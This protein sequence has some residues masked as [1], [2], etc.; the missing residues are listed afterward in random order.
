MV[1]DGWRWRCWRFAAV[2]DGSSG[3]DLDHIAQ[4]PE[5]H[6]TYLVCEEEGA[7]DEGCDDDIAPEEVVGL[8]KE[9]EECIHVRGND[10][11]C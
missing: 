11:R 10:E 8:L 1:T 6:S 4:H 9:E 7:E 3:H 2:E 5:L